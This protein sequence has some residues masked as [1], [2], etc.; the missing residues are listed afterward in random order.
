MA[1]FL[2]I[3]MILEQEKKFSLQKIDKLV[4]SRKG[5]FFVIPAKAGIQYFQRVT[6]K[7]DPVF[8]RGDD[9]LRVH[10]KITYHIIKDVNFLNICFSCGY[11]RLKYSCTLITLNRRKGVKNTQS[12]LFLVI[13]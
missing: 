8:Q 6:S 3:I 4:K 1:N 12:L 10:Q 7:L 13:K 5:P 2:L 9:F 11:N